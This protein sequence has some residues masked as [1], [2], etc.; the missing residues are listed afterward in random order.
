MNT[1]MLVLASSLSDQDLLARVG[2]LAGKERGATAELVAHL[3]ALDDRPSL[4][5]AR[6]YGSLFDYC[7]Q[8]LRLS[9]DATCNRIQAARACR[10]FPVILDLLVSGGMSLTSVRMLRPHLTPENHEAVLA[11]ACGRSRRELEALVAELAPRPDVPSSVRKLP[12]V[13]PVPAPT[14]MPATTVP[15]TRVDA[16]IVARPAPPP[17]IAPPLVPTRRP[18]IETTSPERY[19]IQF[20]I[21]KD[22]HD[23]LR[24]VQAL[25]RREIPDGD[26]AAIFDRALSL[27]LEKVEKAKVGAAAKPRAPRPIRPGTDWQVRT[28]IVPSRDVPRQVQRAVW[29]RDG[30][31]CGFVAPDGHRCTERTFLE[32]HHIRPY[33]LGGLAT[34][35]NIS[36][37][38]RRHNQYEAERAFSPRGASIRGVGV[39][40]AHGFHQPGGV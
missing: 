2:A 1:N 13:T 28:P 15:A 17:S 24:R 21:G 6:G 12:M 29:R 40:E 3:A 35:E 19:R 22:S 39:P 16:A 18:I 10:D 38:C 11:R 33:A 20:T 4:Y 23:K 26:P 34:V 27:L 36:L 8:V 30:G 37:R 25:L 32:F 5:A 7:K 31:Q 14:P 9:E